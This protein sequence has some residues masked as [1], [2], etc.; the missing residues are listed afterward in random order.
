M[1]LFIDDVVYEFTQEE[2]DYMYIGEGVESNV[3]RLNDE[4]F[5]IHKNDRQIKFKLDEETAKY[6]SN[7]K[8]KRIIM[9]KKIIYDVKSNFCGYTLPYLESYQKAILRRKKMDEIVEE[10]KLIEQD[11]ILL[12]EHNV[13][14]EDF[15]L[16]N[17][18]VNR[19]L[20]MIDP[21]S[22]KVSKDDKKY[23]EIVN[24]QKYLEFMI[25]EVFPIA[26]RLNKKQKRELSNYIGGE[27]ISEI[28]DH[29]YEEDDT[30]RKYL[31]RIVK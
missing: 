29:N 1:R 24:K 30:L 3:Y 12:K 6:L 21:G 15:T 18:I 14:L 17:F 7:I 2:L 10:L 28:F 26:V 13:D 8:T 4:V 5:K 20:Y 11:L 22:Y 19:G 23:T 27:Y 25:N 31:K 16:D 9:P